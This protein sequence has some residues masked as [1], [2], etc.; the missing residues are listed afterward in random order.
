MMKSKNFIKKLKK[1]LLKPLEE[2]KNV[3]HQRKKAVLALCK[4]LW[5]K[6]TLECKCF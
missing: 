6:K 1:D 3:N 4:R 2:N 5:T